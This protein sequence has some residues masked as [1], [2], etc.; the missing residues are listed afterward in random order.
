MRKNNNDNQHHKNLLQVLSNVP[1]SGVFLGYRVTKVA[2]KSFK[3]IAAKMTKTPERFA[4]QNKLRR[5][6]RSPKITKVRDDKTAY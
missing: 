1:S 4:Y 5:E 6:K 3:N 2:T